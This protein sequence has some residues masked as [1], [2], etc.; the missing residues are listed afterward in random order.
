M[1]GQLSRTVRF[2]RE[3]LK[4]LSRIGPRP[5]SKNT[6]AVGF[7]VEKSRAEAGEFF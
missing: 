5:V 4:K 3:K 2:V 6:Q 7:A 1:K